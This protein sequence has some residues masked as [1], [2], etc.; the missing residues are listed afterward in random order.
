MPWEEH[1]EANRRLALRVV[2]LLSISEDVLPELAR[3]V[4]ES[5]ARHPEWESFQRIRPGPEG[6]R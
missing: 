6:K 3:D 1:R 5:A 2:G 4:I